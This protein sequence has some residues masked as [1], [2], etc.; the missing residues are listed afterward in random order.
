M[1]DQFNCSFFFLEYIVEFEKLYPSPNDWYQ[2][3]INGRNSTCFD[4]TF[5]FE[6]YLGIIF[7]FK[8]IFFL[9]VL[10]DSS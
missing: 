9:N 1:I 2:G 5:Y 3:I 8:K 6:I 7:F 4:L 10:S